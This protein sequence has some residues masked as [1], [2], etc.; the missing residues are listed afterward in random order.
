VDWGKTN[1]FEKANHPP[2]IILNGETNQNP[3]EI[4][5]K[6]GDTVL[7][8][9]SS[10]SDPD[11]NPLKWEWKY[12]PEAGDYQRDLLIEPLQNGK[13]KIQIPKDASG[14]TL[15]IILRVADEGEPSLCTYQRVIIR[16]E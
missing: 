14:K 12:Y 11:G 4:K 13:A 5:S 10:S 6:T 15:H 2:K 1:S 8:A 16:V 3:L 7:L 9:A